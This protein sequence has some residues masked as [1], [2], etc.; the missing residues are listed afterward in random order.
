MNVCHFYLTDEKQMM[1][2]SLLNF[3]FYFKKSFKQPLPA[4]SSITAVFFN[5][6]IIF[7]HFSSAL[8]FLLH[9]IFHFLSLS[10]LLLQKRSL[11]LFSQPDISSPPF[12]FF[13]FFFFVN[14]RQ[15]VITWAELSVWPAPSAPHPL[16]THKHIHERARRHRPAEIPN[17]HTQTCTPALVHTH[18]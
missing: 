1:K 6:T 4:N 3:P 18:T 9:F 15:Y 8:F 5:V 16:H 12:L 10:C 7:S 14:G 17:T 11:A 13:F 2:I